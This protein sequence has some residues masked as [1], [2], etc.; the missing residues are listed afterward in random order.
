[1]S[2]RLIDRLM[3]TVRNSN[4][5]YQTKHGS[6]QKQADERLV[7]ESLKTYLDSD[8]GEDIFDDDLIH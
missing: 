1:M 6:A 5:D 2:N 3:G 7:Y 4:S 8:D